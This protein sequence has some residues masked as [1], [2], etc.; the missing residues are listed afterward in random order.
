MEVSSPANSRAFSP[1]Q[2]LVMKLG[3]LCLIVWTVF[4]A[5]YSLYTV[6]SA[7]VQAEDYARIQAG[8]VCEQDVVYHMWNAKMGGIYVP[9]ST[10]V[11]PNPYPIVPERTLETAVGTLT[12]IHPP[13]MNRLVHTSRRMREGI[14]SGIIGLHSLY[15]ENKID[16]WERQKL[17][18][19]SI[20]T[21]MVEISERAVINGD[22]YMRLLRPLVMEESCRSCH[23][24]GYQEGAVRGGVS[25]SVPMAPFVQLGMQGLLGAFLLR[26]VVWLGGVGGITYSM[27]LLM[28]RIGERDKAETALRALTRNLENRVAERTKAIEEREQQL[29]VAKEAAEGANQAKNAFLANISHEIRTP[30]NGILGMTDLL[31][32]TEMNTDQAAMAATI[33]SSGTSLL[34]V[35]NDLLDFSKIEAGK[36]RLDPMPFSLRDI[37]FD[38]VRSLA[39]IAHKKNLELLVQIDTDL[40]DHLLADCNRI[41]Q[42]LMNLLSNA[43]KFTSH[44]E[45][46]LHAQCTVLMSHE[47]RM[48]LSVSDTGIGIPYEKQKAIFDAFEQV[49]VSTTRRF[50]GTGLGLSIV[51]KLLELMGASLELDSIPGKGSTFSFELA[52]PV[53]QAACASTM[54]ASIDSVKGKRVLIVD[55]NTTNRQ[56]YLE[57]LSSWNMIAHESA[58]V[59]EALRSMQLSIA[60]QNPFDLVL[61]DYQMPE[62][63]GSDLINA[64]HEKDE[65]RVIPVILLSSC[66]IPPTLEKKEPYRAELVKPV[67]PED[68]LTT[69]REVLGGS[70]SCTAKKNNDTSNIWNDHPSSEVTLDILLVEDMETNQFVATKMLKNLGHT[71]TVAENGQKGVDAALRHKYDVIL[72]DIQMPVMD[73]VEATTQIRQYEQDGIMT[74]YTPIVAMT[75]HALR[76]NKDSYMAAGMDGYVVKPLYTH[77]VLDALDAVTETFSLGRKK[78]AVRETADNGAAMSGD[79]AGQ[80]LSDCMEMLSETDE[81]EIQSGQAE[82]RQPGVIKNTFLNLA[83]VADCIGDDADDIANSMRI[84]MRN[85]PD[86]IT[87]ARQ[88]IENSDSRDLASSAHALKGIIRYYSSGSLYEDLYSLE[89]MANDD[90][91]TDNLKSINDKINSI[92]ENISILMHEMDAYIQNSK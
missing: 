54:H 55:D 80:T 77:T 72:M 26:L 14:V 4:F 44:G 2:R 59:D 25:V 60:M 49:D 69:I 89:L 23:T 29:R 28:R 62:K 87:R 73:G 11:I 35:L 7:I 83:I 78:E 36:M 67:R 50:G 13:L 86:L 66:I 20:D 84:F 16:S 38:T 52:L 90:Y 91:F 10:G 21:T 88:S 43:L 58:S 9:V 24:T 12:K 48:R 56:I 30:L 15:R 31:S 37:V 22:D 34:A 40:P 53:L 75:A 76:E 6:R 39:P 42:I 47:V 5:G 41:R 27:L 46:S 51:K 68:L 18:L 3:I 64:M 81:Q 33:T 74:G 32:Q 8:A 57:Q 45:V 92:H 71:V 63:D 70:V 79:I 61:S 17:Q 1:E 82:S 19:I 85:A 65:L